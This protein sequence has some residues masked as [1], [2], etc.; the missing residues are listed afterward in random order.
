MGRKINRR[1]FI[2]ETSEEEKN[3]ATYF[4]DERVIKYL[5]FGKFLIWKK[6]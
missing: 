6:I 5:K 2:L 3:I 4:F 1:F